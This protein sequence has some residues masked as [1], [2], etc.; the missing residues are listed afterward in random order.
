MSFFSVISIPMKIK[1][2]LLHFKNGFLTPL[3]SDT[4]LGYVFAKGFSSLTSVFHLFQQ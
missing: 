3:E 4:L 2:I 1:K